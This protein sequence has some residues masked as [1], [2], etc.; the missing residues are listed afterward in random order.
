ML[1]NVDLKYIQDFFRGKSVALIGSAPSCLENIG[2][3][4]DGHDIVVRVNNYKVR[5]IAA[6]VGQRC[7]VF[8]S[9]FGS[10]IRKTRQELKADGVR[11]LMCKCPDAECHITEWHRAKG[12]ENGGDFRWIYRMRSGF[13]FCETYVPTRERYMTFF[14]RL[15]KHVPTTGFAAFLEIAETECRSLYVT[16]FDFFSS[17]RHNVNEPWREKNTDDP[18]RHLPAEEA[19]I[20]REMVAKDKRITVD[21]ALQ[22][23]FGK[24]A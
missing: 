23:I 19:K 9:F 17:G 8:Y 21:K 7:D 20:M 18:V 4:I 12:K 16:G 15:G 13:W 5:G 11:L 10:S 3:K 14:E 1:R 22:N 24:A 6:R 2:T